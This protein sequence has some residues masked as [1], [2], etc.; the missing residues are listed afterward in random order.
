FVLDTSGSM[1]ETTFVWD[2]GSP[3]VTRAEAA[4]RAFRLFIAGGDGP[5]GTHFDG[6]STERGADAVGL[7]TFSH[8]PHPVCPPPLNHSRLLTILDNVRPAGA[9]DTAT[10][11]RGPLAPGVNPLHRADPR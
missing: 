7:V 2:P 11:I 3:P 4:R 10:N 1:Q 8:W 5:D 9:R 6:R